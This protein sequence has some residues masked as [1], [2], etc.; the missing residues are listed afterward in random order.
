MLELYINYAKDQTVNNIWYFNLFITVSQLSNK[1]QDSSESD[2]PV[3]ESGKLYPSS[4][5]ET[6][7]E[8]YSLK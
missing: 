1:K 7:F 3:K 5:S 4:S 2:S 6:L 8:T